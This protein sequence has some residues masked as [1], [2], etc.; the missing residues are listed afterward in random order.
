MKKN[1][2]K[3]VILI[4]TP[5]AVHGLCRVIR[6]LRLDRENYLMIGLFCDKVLNY[7]VKKYY[8]DKFCDGRNIREFHFKNKDSGGWPGDSRLRFD[9]G[10]FIYAGI[11]ERMKIKDYFVP[12]RCLY[13]IDKLNVDADISLGDNYTDV[14]SSSLGTNSVV[15]RTEIGMAA[16]RAEEELIDQIS[17]E[18]SKIVEAQDMNWRLNNL[19][20]GKL[21]EFKH[22]KTYCGEINNGVS[23]GDDFLNY[24]AQYDVFLKKS[25]IGQKY[26][27]AP[28]KLEKALTEKK[29]GK[30]TKFFSRGMY[31]VKRKINRIKKGRI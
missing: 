14:G 26:D 8:E 9:D 6:E 30:L 18:F 16:W 5:C 25:A 7:N 12:E 1:R 27:S 3:K 21:F 22:R 11:G 4:G 15:V 28:E 2:T 17:V 19:R 31:F 23:G 24:E 10:S 13:C 20:Y 29:K